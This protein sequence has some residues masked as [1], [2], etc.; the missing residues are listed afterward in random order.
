MS[1][2][3]FQGHKLIFGKEDGHAVVLVRIYSRSRLLEP[4]IFIV[5]PPNLAVASSI[6][7][8]MATQNI[9]YTLSIKVKEG[10]ADL[11]SNDE[12]PYKPVVEILQDT[13]RMELTNNEKIEWVE[14][15]KNTSSYSTVY[16]QEGGDAVFDLDDNGRTGR[17]DIMFSAPKPD[18]KVIW[19]AIQTDPPTDSPLGRSSFLFDAFY[20]T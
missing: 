3:A 9:D 10:A 19:F 5:F 7:F 16:S 20:N 14:V 17:F 15:N 6:R 18:S 12:Y 8:N 11:V 4:S 13:S 2:L 1:A